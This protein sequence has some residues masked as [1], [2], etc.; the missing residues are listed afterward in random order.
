MHEMIFKFGAKRSCEPV[1]SNANKAVEEEI[2]Y[3][4]RGKR[5]NMAHKSKF[6]KELDD[7]VL[8]LSMQ[9]LKVVR[10]MKTWNLLIYQI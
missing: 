3:R 2:K 1:G 9:N 5:E 8:D 7:G 6:Y 10:K 4:I